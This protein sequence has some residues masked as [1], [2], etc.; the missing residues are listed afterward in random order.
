VEDDA[1]DEQADSGANG[2]GISEGVV[3]EMLQERDGAGKRE[4]QH[5]PQGRE[6][7]EGREDPAPETFQVI[8]GAR[9]QIAET[10]QQ[11]MFI[12]G[13]VRWRGRTGLFEHA[14]KFSVALEGGGGSLFEGGERLLFGRERGLEFGEGRLGVGQTGFPVALGLQF[15]GLQFVFAG[16]FT[17]IDA[18]ERFFLA[19]SMGGDNPGGTPLVAG[20]DGGAGLDEFSFGPA[21]VVGQAGVEQFEAFVAATEGGTESEA[22]GA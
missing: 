15:L 3:A 18:L 1:E 5:D 13:G 12:P 10:G 11:L 20:L 9:D 2:V 17:V 8:I 21:D 14:N 22:L 19:G 4:D 7:E 6:P 16:A